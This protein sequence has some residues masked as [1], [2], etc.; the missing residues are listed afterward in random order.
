M[1]PNLAD[2]LLYELQPS[3]TELEGVAAET[4]ELVDEASEAEESEDE[5]LD[6]EDELLPLQTSSP[7]G[8]SR[9]SVLT[10]SAVA[11]QRLRPFQSVMESS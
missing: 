3:T 5:E 2:L 1:R 7:T 11:V 4:A 9:M 10:S 8:V 6:E